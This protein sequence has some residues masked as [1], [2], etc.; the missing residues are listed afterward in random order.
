MNAP[1][2]RLTR[3]GQD[4]NVEIAIYRSEPDF[5]QASPAVVL[6]FDSDHNLWWCTSLQPSYGDVGWLARDLMQEL[7]INPWADVS[8]VATF[9]TVQGRAA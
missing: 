6:T 2:V 8:H 9:V 4:V 1:I 3:D 7:K 5:Y